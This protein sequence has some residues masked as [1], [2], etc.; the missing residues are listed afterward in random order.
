M[1]ELPAPNLDDRRFQDLV[2]EA[3]LMVQQRCPEW[4]DHNVSDPGVTLI[5]LFAS[6]VDQLVYRLNQVPERNYVKFLD[7]LGVRLLPPTAA[8]TS[9]TFWLSSPLAETVRVPVGTEVATLRTEADE[10]ITFTVVEELA[11]VPCELTGVGASTNP[12]EV[13]DH[14]DD[15][16]ARRGFAC[17]D[18]TPKPGDALYVALNTPVPR[19]AVLLRFDCSIQGYG[20]DPTDPPV[21]WEAWTG[22]V[23]EAC[24]VDHDDTGGL[25][26][27]GDV[28]I[29]VPA[30]H[31]ASTVAGTR[32]GWVRCRITEP[33]EGQ[34]F[35]SNP[36]LIRTVTATTVGGTTEVTHCEVVLDETIGLSEGVAGQRFPLR[37]R[38]LVP[39]DDPLVVE[40]AAGDGWEIWQPV[41][42]FAESEAEDRCFMVD[43]VAG[44]ISFGP[45][46]RL[47]DGTLRQYGAVPPKGAPIRIAMYRAGGGRRGNVARGALS[48]LKS[49][50]PY[51]TR[52]ENRLL[53][54]GGVDGEGVES[55]KVRGPIMFRTRGR[56]VTTED[57]EELAREARPDAARVRCV[58]AGS[59]DVAGG[60]VRVLVV[61][62]VGDASGRLDFGDLVPPDDMLQAVAAY[63]DERRLIGTRL[64][65][66]PPVYQGVTVVARV[67]ARPHT[68][69]ARL[70]ADALTALYR[71]FHPLLGG[72]DGSG[73]PFGRPVHVGE[74]FSVLQRLRGTELVEDARL[75]GADPITGQR[76]DMTQRIVLGPNALVFPYEHQVAVI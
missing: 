56:A 68:D 62:A 1:S 39:M 11:I 40:V 60:A 2:D 19:C 8:R 71:Y 5:E 69:T 47:A 34:P 74:V 57:F 23:W 46:V 4:T 36:P 27:A 58:A 30:G 67:R 65:V 21:A 55:A 15:L 17:F 50:L 42:S 66:E 14:T 51:I 26:R 18:A 12:A 70:Q 41:D 3:K 53:A 32:A 25:N 44:E 52:V 6:M 64:V 43:A 54:R 76:G 13:V 33:A 49:S 31:A 61:P 20:V 63:L 22:T 9:E 45:G 28:V 16:L 35:Y 7:L 38:P 72:P 29:H 59:D 75:F 73:W 37:H 48:I 10:A 24:D